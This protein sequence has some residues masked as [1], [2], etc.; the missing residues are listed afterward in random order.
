MAKI[1]LGEETGLLAVVPEM[2]EASDSP[3]KYYPSIH[4]CRD[5]PLPVSGEGEMTVEFCVKSST[6]ST[7]E[8]GN[9][10]YSYCIEVQSILS[11]DSESA[12]SEEAD[13]LPKNRGKA[14]ED[15]LD[16]IAAAHKKLKASY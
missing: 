9:T 10:K 4:V 2:P 6:I 1:D 12:G 13:D 14:T 5:E 8:E 15:A 16:A 7:D 3:K 11:V